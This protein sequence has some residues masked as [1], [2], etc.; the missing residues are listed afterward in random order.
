VTGID[1]ANAVLAKKGLQRWPLVEYLPPEPFVGWVEKLMKY[2]RKRK[3]EK[4]KRG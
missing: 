3:R 4:Y 2:G 1:A